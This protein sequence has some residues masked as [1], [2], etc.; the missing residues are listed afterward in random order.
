MSDF[1]SELAARLARNSEIAQ[2][3]ADNTEA[4]REWEEQRAQREEREA[5]ERAEARRSR[6]EELATQ[7]ERVATQLKESAPE[8]F[9]VRVGRTGEGD[10]VVARISSRVLEPARAL[11]VELDLPDDEVLARW[12]S[13][14]GGSLEMWRVMEV[15]D[16]LL[17]EL[18]L[19]VAD[20]ELW[21][22]ARRPPAFPG[23][24]DLT[25]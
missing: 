12:T 24:P 18:V 22:S 21:R 4:M 15:E 23:A 20:Q 6:F 5:A 2:E 1:E 17:T 14:V 19:Q 13:D 25:E 9:V 11:L 10:Q 3:R 7:L 16:S 8:Q